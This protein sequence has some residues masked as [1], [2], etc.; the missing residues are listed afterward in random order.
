[1]SDLNLLDAD[2]VAESCGVVD[3][4]KREVLVAEVIQ[5][6]ERHTI[7]E[8][9]QRELSAKNQRDASIDLR[10]EL[11]RTLESVRQFRP[12]FAR[13]VT[14][15]DGRLPLERE[16]VDTMARLDAVIASL[17]KKAPTKTEDVALKAALTEVARVFQKRSRWKQPPRVP[18]YRERLIEFI[19]ATGLVRD[20]SELAEIYA[21]GTAAKKL[22]NRV[23]LRRL[24]RMIPSALLEPGPPV[25][26]A[27]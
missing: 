11:V 25:R 12:E 3:E 15:S 21:P 27:R 4:G 26:R 18:Q 2:A 16:L 20:A 7:Q 5:I 9:L 1:M 13:A 23:L 24:K 14:G 22:P 6:L 10:K 8:N 19:K 17:P